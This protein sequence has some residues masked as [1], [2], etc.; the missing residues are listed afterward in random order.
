MLTVLWSALFSSAFAQKYDVPSSDAKA[1]NDSSF[2]RQKDAT[3]YL[4]MVFKKSKLFAR[5]TVSKRKGKLYPSVVP[6]IGY[7][8][9]TKLAASLGVNGAFYTDNPDSVNLSVL[10]LGPTVTIKKQLI[11]PLQSNIWSAKNKYNLVGNWIFYKF[12]EITYGLG[13]HTTNADADHIDYSYVLYRETLLRTIFPDFFAGI[14]YNLDYHFNVVETQTPGNGATDF[15]KYGLTSTSVSSG[16]TYNLLY[17]NR[18]NPINPPK[19]YY[20]NVILRTNYTFLGSNSNWQSLLL[21]FRKYFKVSK[22]SDNVLA[23]WSYTW[24]TLGGKPPYLDL[25][26]TAWDTYSNQGRGYIQS[27][28]RGYNLL[29]LEGEY[30][31][32]ITRNGFLGGVVFADG[33]TVSDWPGNK[34]DTV[35]PGVGTGIRFKLNK[36]SNTNGAI[37]YAWGRGSQGIF[38]NIGEVF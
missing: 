35:W 17:D 13:G 29:D 9:H 31:F 23:I 32:K 4:Q 30:R 22:H 25:P 19:G 8:L 15:E 37:D 2:A 3:D 20:L 6:V 27:R 5:D 28:F 11:V 38:V 16:I 21:D 14:G 12:P 33:Q 1:N 26:A 36:Y 10:N 34:I 7:S 18:R 24:L